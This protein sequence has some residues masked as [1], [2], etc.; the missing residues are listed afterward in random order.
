MVVFVDDDAYFFELFFGTSLYYCALCSVMGG[1][2]HL[3][4]SGHFPRSILVSFVCTCIMLSLC[5][6]PLATPA[7]YLSWTRCWRPRNVTW[8][9]ARQN[10]QVRA[11]IL[12]AQSVSVQFVSVREFCPGESFSSEQCSSTLVFEQSSRLYW[13]HVVETIWARRDVRQSFEPFAVYTL[14]GGRREVT[15]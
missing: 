6:A 7:L 14:F 15:W 11:E 10:N 3:S 8:S 2:S 5:R 4:P 1:Y 13:V 9:P 12:R